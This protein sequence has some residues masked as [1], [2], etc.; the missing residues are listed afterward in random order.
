MLALTEERRR[1]CLVSHYRRLMSSRDEQ[2]A[3]TATGNLWGKLSQ[4]TCGECR[5]RYPRLRAASRRGSRFEGSLREQTRPRCPNYRAP[6][7]AA[8]A[9]PRSRRPTPRPLP[10]HKQD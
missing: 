9:R 6:L 5:Y 10:L 2:L 3:T 7:V 1:D 8:A 4:L